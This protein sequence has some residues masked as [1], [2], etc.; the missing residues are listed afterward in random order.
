MLSRG[1]TGLPFCCSLVVCIQTFFSIEKIFM[2]LSPI[3]IRKLICIIMV[4]AIIL[5]CLSLVADF[6]PGLSGL[7]RSMVST[8]NRTSKEREIG[9]L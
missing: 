5:N 9:L 4:F 1:L 2:D 8:S 3:I 7:L 6:L